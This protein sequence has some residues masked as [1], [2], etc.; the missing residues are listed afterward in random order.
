MTKS[1][2][3]RP[4]EYKAEYAALVLNYCKLGAED[5]QLA[6]FFQVSEATINNW[7][8]QHPEFLESIRTG[9]DS[10]NVGLVE[11]ALIHSALG[12]SHDDVHITAYEGDITET[13]ITKYYPPNPASLIFFLKN[14]D[15]NRWKD[16]QE[17]ELSG[18]I[19]VIIDRKPDGDRD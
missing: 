9:K 18:N 13:P 3:G 8:H 15:R 19:T 7:K 2:G 11:K 16:K 6:D 12:F 14:R 1:K 4:T 5:K 17:H 10:F